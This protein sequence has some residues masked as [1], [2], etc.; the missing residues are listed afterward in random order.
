[1]PAKLKALMEAAERISMSTLPVADLAYGTTAD[2]D[3]TIDPGSFPEPFRS[4][5]AWQEPMHWCGATRIG[6]PSS[7]QVLIPA[8]F[9]YCPFDERDPRAMLCDPSSNG[10]AAGFSIDDATARATREAFERHAIL[11]SHYHRLGGREVAW[12]SLP[13]DPGALCMA[14]EARVLGLELR[15]SCLVEEPY[16][17]AVCRVTDE[18]G[19]FPALTMGSACGLSLAQA[20]SGAISEALHA[21]RQA[22]D[23]LGDVAPVAAA[24]LESIEDRVVHWAQPGTS[25]KLDFLFGDSMPLQDGHTRAVLDEGYVADITTPNSAGPASRS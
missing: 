10:A 9:V 16:P 22:R 8:Q 4:S 20:A 11:L 19:R 25:Q 6:D 5:P 17:V 12:E 18:T 1:M 15:V 14:L 23:F 3:G 21:R 7:G 13:L 2:L 24:E